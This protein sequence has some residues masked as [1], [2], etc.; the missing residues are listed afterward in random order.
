MTAQ[1]CS[2]GD[3]VNVLD[4]EITPVAERLIAQR[5]PV[6]IYTGRGAPADL[7]S[8][9]PSLPIL[10]NR[11]GPRCCAVPWLV[12]LAPAERLSRPSGWRP[13]MRRR[14]RRGS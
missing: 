7:R 5:V 10:L 1:R 14:S 3:D 11:S 13:A 4:G 12:C 8:K 6:L 2:H 9:Y